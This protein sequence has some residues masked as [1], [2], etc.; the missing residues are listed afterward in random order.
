MRE[1]LDEHRLA[2]EWMSGPLPPSAVLEV[3][4]CKY[5]LPDCE[6]LANVLNCMDMCKFQMCMNKKIEEEEEDIQV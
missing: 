1:P 5:Q 3:L 4:S 6:F 2:T